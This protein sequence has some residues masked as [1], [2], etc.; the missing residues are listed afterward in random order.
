MKA[1]ALANRRVEAIETAETAV[2]VARSGRNEKEAQ[3]IE[4]W[5]SNYKL[6]LKQGGQSLPGSVSVPK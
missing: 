6:K 1:L 5:L 2:K 4:T 3:E